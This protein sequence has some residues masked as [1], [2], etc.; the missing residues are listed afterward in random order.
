MDRGSTHHL[1]QCVG[2]LEKIVPQTPNDR[3][4]TPQTTGGSATI[5]MEEPVAPAPPLIKVD[6]VKV[7]EKPAPKNPSPPAQ[8]TKFV[9]GAFFGSFQ[10]I[11]LLTVLKQVCGAPP[12]RVVLRRRRRV[13]PGALIRPE[14][15]NDVKVANRVGDEVTPP[16]SL[17]T[18]VARTT[19][20][21]GVLPSSR[22]ILCRRQCRTLLFVRL[23]VTF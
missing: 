15:Y 13:S 19:R 4:A 21:V 18:T 3:T 2:N 8:S 23:F 6:D 14:T 10:K 20:K 11:S 16:I 7:E 12:S 1:R 9:Q 5:K 17:Y 22:A